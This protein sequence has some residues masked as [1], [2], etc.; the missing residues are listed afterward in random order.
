MRL[1]D[2]S[3]A[4]Q[5][6][7]WARAVLAGDVRTFDEWAAQ[8]AVQTDGGAD[9]GS[10]AGASDD[11]PLPSDAALELVRRVTAALPPTEPGTLRDRLRADV[12]ADVLR[13]AAD[14]TGTA[15]GSPAVDEV[16]AELVG[17]LLAGVFVR[18][19]ALVDEAR[20]EVARG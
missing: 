3:A 11:R 5:R 12:V 1:D 16:D 8:P 17:E 14:G 19:L 18:T 10:E 6:R 7:A 15:H 13:L 20:A 4:A 9:A 2:E